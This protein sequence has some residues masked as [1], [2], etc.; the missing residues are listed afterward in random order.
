MPSLWFYRSNFPGTRFYHHSVHDQMDVL[1]FDLLAR[2]AEVAGG[3]VAELA[4]S[5]TLPF[6]AEI[7]LSQRKLI[8]QSRKD[9][10]DCVCDW[11]TPGLMRPEGKPWREF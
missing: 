8:A 7:P 9:L 6:P 3:M 2:T 1:D 10:Y 11:R 5:E 4:Q